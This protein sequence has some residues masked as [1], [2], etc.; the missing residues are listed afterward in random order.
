MLSFLL[1]N[2]SSTRPITGPPGPYL[3][4]CLNSS[5]PLEI[6]TYIWGFHM[7]IVLII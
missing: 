3:A 5:R 1:H 6:G 7:Q 2:N 4:P